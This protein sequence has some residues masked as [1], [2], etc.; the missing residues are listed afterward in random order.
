MGFTNPNL[1]RRIDPKERETA[2][3]SVEYNLT[4]DVPQF[5]FAPRKYKLL[6]SGVN[7]YRY[8][9]VTNHDEDSTYWEIP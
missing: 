8:T 3:P 5:E 9:E 4:E 1:H 7:S 6:V 2:D